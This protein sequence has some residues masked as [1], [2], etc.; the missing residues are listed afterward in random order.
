MKLRKLNDLEVKMIADLAM[1]AVMIFA[2]MWA[3]YILIV[4]FQ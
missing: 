3:G 2:V 4:L 1:G